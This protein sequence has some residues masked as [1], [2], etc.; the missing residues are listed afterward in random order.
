ML[1]HACFLAARL[2]SVAVN[3]FITIC[4]TLLMVCALSFSVCA[5]SESGSAA[6][7]GVITDPNGQALA[8][9][10]VTIRNQET[11]Y[12]RKLTT[13]VRGQFVAAVMPVGT[14]TVEASAHGFVSAKREKLPLT[15]GATE[16]VNLSLKV[17]TVNEEVVIS[18]SQATVNTE[19]GATGST[20]VQR[21]VADL[22]IRGRNFTEF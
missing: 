6:M 8:G 16:T 7:E 11:G 20:I 10:T 1:S 14:Y 13:D 19:E 22:P 4:S 3:V 21:S 2:H 15:V 5:Q 18:D 12:V 9:A 17:G